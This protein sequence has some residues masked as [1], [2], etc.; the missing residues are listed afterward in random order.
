MKTVK[1]NYSPGKLGVKGSAVPKSATEKQAMLLAVFPRVIATGGDVE[2]LAAHCGISVSE[3]E[4]LIDTPEFAGELV[5]AQAK[6]EL[7]GD[8][9]A[10][11]AA[12]VTLAMLQRLHK[13]VQAG[14][15]DVDDVGAFLPKVHRVVEHSERMAAAKGTNENLPTIVIN[16]G[17][18]ADAGI[19]AV[20]HV[21][22][23]ICDMGD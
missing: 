5:A 8:L 21:G 18:G 17:T 12:K 23:V 10:P 20:P 13:A 16:I 6:A 3:V 9:L 11:L 1:P 4:A 7:G 22:A 14:E 15:L 2:Q 19:Q